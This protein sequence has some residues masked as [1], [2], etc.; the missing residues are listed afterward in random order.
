LIAVFALRFRL[1]LPL[2]LLPLFSTTPPFP[3]Q[4]HG[5]DGRGGA[6]GVVEDGAA[7][8]T[9]SSAARISDADV[10]S[11]VLS[12]LCSQGFD[13]AAAAFRR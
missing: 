7:A 11:V 3:M 2:L 10:A 5:G 1:L 13:R 12:Y 6:A 9:S 4:A 8:A